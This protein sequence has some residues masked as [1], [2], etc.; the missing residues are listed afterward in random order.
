MGTVKQDAN[1]VPEEWTLL[2]A[3]VNRLVKN[4]KDYELRLS[5]EDLDAIAGG[6][7]DARVRYYVDGYSTKLGSVTQLYLGTY[8]TAL[9]YC[10][11]YGVDPACIT[12]VV[13]Y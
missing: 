13:F 8:E 12:E 11:K 1:G 3:G 5:V 9:K 7:E 2:H 4:G 10:K 6:A